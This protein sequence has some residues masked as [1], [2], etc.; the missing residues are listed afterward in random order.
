MIGS[1]R[2]DP[3]LL[4]VGLGVEWHVRYGSFK[5]YPACRLLATAIEYAETLKKPIVGRQAIV[6]QSG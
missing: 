5:S 3:S 4:E 1:D 6:Q 2:F